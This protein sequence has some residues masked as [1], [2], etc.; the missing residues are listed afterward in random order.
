MTDSAY[1]R[2]L[3]ESISTLRPELLGY[4]TATD[5][6]IG[7][8]VFSVAGSRYRILRPVLSFLAWRGV[9]FPEYARDVPFTI[10]NTPTA[11]GTLD[12]VRTFQFPDRSRTLVDSMRVVD[13]LL[14]DY[15]GKRGGLEVRLRLT[16]A[17]GLLRMRSDQLWLH[18]L[19]AR[20]PLPPIATVRVDESWAD[21][22]QH[23]DVRLRSPLL[24]EWFR[25][26]GS[27]TYHHEPT[28]VV[29]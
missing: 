25:Y 14:H 2:V 21:G 17:D 19:G 9:L 12:A 7:S 16:I 5:V 13:G 22:K 29:E 18:V 10:T 11:D 23:V 8:G 1:R 3:G 15:L 26:A 24:G 6:G 28:P 20:I 4:F 27:F